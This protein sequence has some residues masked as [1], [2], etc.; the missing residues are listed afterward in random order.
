MKKSIKFLLTILSVMLM[1]TL[2]ACKESDKADTTTDKEIKVGVLVADVSGEEALGFKSYLQDYISKNYN[3]TFE[4]TAQLE[5]AAAEK[6]AIEDF[7]SRG[8]DAVI[9]MSSNDRST[10]LQAAIDNEIYYVVGSGVLD[11]EVYDTYKNSEYFLGEVGPS[12]DTEY[13]AGY[14]M[15]QY[16]KDKGVTSIGLYGAFIPNPMHVYR[17]AGVLAGLGL[18]YDGLLDKDTVVGAI[19]AGN[20]IDATKISGDIS[21]SYMSG[22]DPDTIYATL[23]T[24]IGGGI[25]VYLSVGMTTTFF[26]AQLNE[27]GIEYS[28]IDSFTSTNGE[29]MNTGKLAYL[30]GKYSSSI[31]P[32]YALIANAVNGNRIVDENGC[33]PSISQGYAVA[34]NYDEFSQIAVND[35]GENPIYSKE[36][37]DTM[38]GADITYDTFKSIVE[39]K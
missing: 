6:S 3:V 2:T 17:A 9:S 30:A 13:E 38:I 24:I 1:L 26:A 23:G 7:A 5:D 36:V 31:G 33:A 37:L 18:E 32:V 11:S 15:G 19:Y 28:D 34:T 12:N 35:A 22:Y 10:Q 27:A 4:Y 14:A 21:V 39:S 29:Y 25:D 20:G 8:F 16:Y